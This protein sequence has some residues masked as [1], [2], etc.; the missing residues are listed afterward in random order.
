MKPLIATLAVIGFLAGVV[1]PQATYAQYS[2]GGGDKPVKA[3]TGK[4]SAKGK[5]GSGGTG[6]GTPPP[7]TKY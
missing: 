7:A 3:D 2:G 5:K 6:S 4:K 1:V